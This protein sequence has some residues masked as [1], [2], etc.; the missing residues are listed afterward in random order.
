V[1][2]LIWRIWRRVRLFDI[3]YRSY[4]TAWILYFDCPWRAK[5]MGR[6]WEV[7]FT[8]NLGLGG[9]GW[10]GLTWTTSRTQFNKNSRPEKREEKRTKLRN[11]DVK[12]ALKATPA[13]VSCGGRGSPEGRQH[14][15]RRSPVIPISLDRASAGSNCGI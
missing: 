13:F 10:T 5:K 4:E 12:L 15:Q 1:S 9:T 2:V 8:E 7:N 14:I 6:E 11:N 3:G